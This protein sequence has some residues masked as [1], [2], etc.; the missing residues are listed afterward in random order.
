[1]TCPACGAA[2]DQIAE[3]CPACHAIIAPRLDGALAP[4]PSP[5]TPPARG[6]GERDAPSSAAEE[7]AA[8]RREVNERVRQRRKR[9]GLPSALPL[10]PEG[11]SAGE[12]SLQTGEDESREGRSGSDSARAAALPQPSDIRP[13]LADDDPLGAMSLR[14]DDGD[15]DEESDPVEVV[16]ERAEAVPEPSFSRRRVAIEDDEGPVP[17]TDLEP[18]A[19][20]DDAGG[21][22]DIDGVWNLGLDDPTPEVRPLERPATAAERLQAALVD[23]AI[24]ATVSAAIVY[25]S[26]KAAQVGPLALLP[27]WPYLG[28]FVAFFGLLY[29]AYFTGISGCT[30]GKTAFGL[31]V[32]DTTGRA[33]GV[34]RAGA[35]ALVG[36]VGTVVVL[37]ALPVFFDPAR[38]TLPDRVFR[39]RVIRL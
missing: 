27:V 29:A 2:L 10:F 34:W 3:R 17:L 4:A 39:T 9:R 33:P 31:R 20:D 26:F 6:R 23:L 37:G 5:L 16:A 18:E 25:F 12:A 11:S 32:V 7:A 21:D 35:R 36:A 13:S 28:G 15:L 14:H 22:E 19:F 8:W 24:L 30:P 38:R 1:M